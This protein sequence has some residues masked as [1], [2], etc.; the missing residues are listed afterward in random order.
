MLVSTSLATTSVG[1]ISFGADN[2]TTY[3]CSDSLVAEQIVNAFVNDVTFDIDC[4]GNN[5]RVSDCGGTQLGVNTNN[6]N[7]N[8]PTDGGEVRPC[9]GGGNSLSWGGINSPTCNSLTQ[10]ITISVSYW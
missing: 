1:A 6:C 7:C 8:H 4:D 9:F 3:T 10:E 2:T 5:W